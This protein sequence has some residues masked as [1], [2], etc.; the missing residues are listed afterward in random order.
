[1]AA[2]AGGDGAAFE[3]L[4]KRYQHPLL[5]FIYRFIGDRAEAED[6]A[7]EVFV[8]VW[9]AAGTYR[10][11]A[12]FSTWLF[13]IAANRCINELKAARRRKLLLFFRP[14]AAGPAGANRVRP[15]DG[16]PSPEDQLLAAEQNARLAAAL[17]KLPPSQRMAL[18]LK[19]Y[20]G[21]SYAEIAGVLGRSVSAVDALLVRAKQNLLKNKALF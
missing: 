14:D 3:L 1:M 18:I 20:Q 17:Q 6:L 8:R 15:S 16:P 19:W 2:V 4:V 9:K 7:Q 13:R 10:P 11:A 5:N 21:M 12:K